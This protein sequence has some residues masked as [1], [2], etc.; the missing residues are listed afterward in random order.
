[1]LLKS[2][3]FLFTFSICRVTIVTN[4]VISHEWEHTGRHCDRDNWDMSVV[5]C[6]AKSCVFMLFFPRRFRLKFINIEKYHWDENAIFSKEI[7]LLLYSC[8]RYVIFEDI[9]ITMK[10][11]FTHYELCRTICFH[12][13][14]LISSSQTIVSNMYLSK[15]VFT[16]IVFKHWCTVNIN[17]IYCSRSYDMKTFISDRKNNYASIYDINDIFC[18]R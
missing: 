10:Y 1:M 5:I 11:V 4:P 12:L 16:S 14:R 2:R 6:N 3:R 17:K 9:Y 18:R 7:L 15:T 8:R 13:K